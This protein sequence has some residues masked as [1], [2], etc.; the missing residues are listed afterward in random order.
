MPWAA[1]LT[2]TAAASVASLPLSAGFASDWLLVQAVLAGPRIGAPWLQ[3]T[4]AMAVAAIGLG[5]ALA[6][7]AMLRLAGLLFLGRPRAPRALGARDAPMWWRVPMAAA[8]GLLLLAGLLP[9]ATLA[10]AGMVTGWLGLGTVAGGP[11]FGLAGQGAG[12]LPLPLSALL[13]AVGAGVWLA[14]G[15][16]GRPEARHGR[17]WDGGAAP[18][19]SW[20]PLGDPLTQPSAAGFAEPLRR[21][22]ADPWRRGQ[23]AI[24]GARPPARLARAARDSVAALAAVARDHGR[25]AFLLGVL[26]LAV[27][28]LAR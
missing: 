17:A 10:A 22:L 2:L 9:G 14:V 16:G 3:V 21:M 28:V 27:V 19:P 25:G 26:L 8:A 18:P 23:A 4:M 20:L 13:A 24:A 15:R 12:Y 7:A 6:A 1:A 11:A 5:A